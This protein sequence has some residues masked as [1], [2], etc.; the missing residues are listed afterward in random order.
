M[1]YLSVVECNNCLNKNRLCRRRVFLVLTADCEEGNK[2]AF[3][4]IQSARKKEDIN[5]NLSLLSVIPD[6]PHVGKSLKASF[7]NW[8]LKLGHE[9][10]NLSILWNLRNRSLPEVSSQVKRLIPKNDFVRNRD[11]QDPS[12]VLAITDESLLEFLSDTGSVTSTIIPD[13]CTVLRLSDPL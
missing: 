5:H 13:F 7:S 6:C 8:F 11:R 9:R 4:K 2:I 12:A 3:E 10:G 1:C